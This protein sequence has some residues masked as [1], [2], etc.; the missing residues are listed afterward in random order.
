VEQVSLTRLRGR[1]FLDDCQP[2]TERQKVTDSQRDTSNSSPTD[3][4]NDL[5]SVAF[6]KSSGS[7]LFAGSDASIEL[8][9]DA[10]LLHAQ[11]LDES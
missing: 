4:V 3:K 1:D 6:R 11:P 10:I 2:G 8:D 7:P 9:R 5:Q